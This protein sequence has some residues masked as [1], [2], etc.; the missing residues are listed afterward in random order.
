MIWKEIVT[1]LSAAAVAPTFDTFVNAFLRLSGS[2][3][4][5]ALEAMLAKVAG[6]WWQ[7]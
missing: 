2:T 1:S 3:E 7:N 5:G 4:E 6:F